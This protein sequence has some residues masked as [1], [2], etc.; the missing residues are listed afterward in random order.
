MT[1]DIEK[2]KDVLARAKDARFLL[3]ADDMAVVIGAME[4]CVRGRE[5]PRVGERISTE[6][7]RELSES[8]D[9][10]LMLDLASAL[11]E[12]LTLRELPEGMESA[13]EAAGYAWSKIPFFRI[14]AFIEQRDAQHASARRALEEENKNL[15]ALL[16]PLSHCETCNDTGQMSVLASV[17]SEERETYEDEPCAECEAYP[18]RAKARAALNPPAAATAPEGE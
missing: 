9:K 10:T 2:L 1:V 13:K 3:Q 8:C 7:L 11:R 14:E 17:D 5:A 12:L 16:K 4:E 6:R 15:R 18:D